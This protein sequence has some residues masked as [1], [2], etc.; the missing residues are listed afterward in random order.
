VTANYS[1]EQGLVPLA[2][3]LRYLQVLRL[4]V[5]S[6][7]IVSWFALPSTRGMRAAPTA[8]WSALYVVGMLP[9]VPAW[10]LPRR[11]TLWIFGFTLLIDGAF[12][13]W[14]TYGQTGLGTPLAY[15]L[16]L[17]VVSVT[18]LA[19][20]RTGL[21][22]AFWH[23]LLVS[24]AYQLQV[25]GYMDHAPKPAFAQLPTLVAA[26]WLVTIATASF[27]AVN[28]RE[29]RRRNYDLHAL[30]RF[31]FAL[32][33]TSDP[34]G[35]GAALVDAV[36]DEFGMQRVLLVAGPSGD[37][38]LLAG[39]GNSPSDAALRPGADAL[40]IRAQTGHTGVRVK[41]ADPVENPWLAAVLPGARNLVAVPLHAE[42]QA[43]GV[44]IFEHGDGSGRIE[45]RV[46]E[47]VE[48]FVSQAALALQNA[49]LLAQIR[50]LAATDGLTGI[51]NR[52]TFEIELDRE[53]RRAER[54][55][56]PFSV[57]LL[58]LDHFKAHN[59]E[60]GHQQGDRTL[61]SVA[62]AL[63]DAGRGA[64]LAARYG[65][66]EFVV[67]LPNTDLTGATTIAE[68]LRATI[69]RLGNPAIT[70]SLGVATYPLHGSTPLE[71]VRAADAALYESKRTGRD[72]VTAAAVV[73]ALQA[74]NDAD[75]S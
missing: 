46:I 30:S 25:A 3:R 62:K 42:S 4:V 40:L 23:S 72:R 45:R 17:H 73:P 34:D 31:G 21:K 37:P 14:M 24:A 53:F 39:R 71:I 60:H 75:A 10:R 35:I 12:I 49:W 67:I 19:S 63:A 50:A 47:M 52:R 38:H 2:N 8:A 7:V 59:D 56:L 68:R 33:T 43:F 64:D 41:A 13:A 9:S 5:A 66:E 58:D 22:I 61:Q 18:L 32:E 15:L 6:V 74:V 51:A 16:L 70:A 29:L 27:G 65:G 36:V 1:T 55:E 28:E 69:S 54:A 26:I 20:F 48:Q 11:V 57:V 44:L